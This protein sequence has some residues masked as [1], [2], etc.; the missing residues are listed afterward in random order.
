M[1]HNT[2]NQCEREVYALNQSQVQEN[3]L[4]QLQVAIEFCCP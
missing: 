1:H 2:Q 4:D 3:E